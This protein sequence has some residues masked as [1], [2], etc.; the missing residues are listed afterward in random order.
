M[1]ANQF[2]EQIG[3]EAA[4]PPVPP[5][6]LLVT[7]ADFIVG[8]RSAGVPLQGLRVIERTALGVALA[9]SLTIGAATATD[10]FATLTDAVGIG[11]A[12]RLTL[13]VDY[14]SAAAGGRPVI[15]PYFA[16]GQLEHGFTEFAQ[17]ET[18]ATQISA[19]PFSFV[20]QQSNGLGP[21]SLA[22]F[23]LTAPSNT[24]GVAQRCVLPID[25]EDLGI[26]AGAFVKFGLVD[27]AV[28]PGTCSIVAVVK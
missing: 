1:G 11:S 19:G 18:F 14:I 27:A 5:E 15:F 3:F 2:P 9:N 16:L 13:Y 8:E 28:T 17:L 23:T 10:P 20:S 7:E 25:L 6:P 26:P 22:P 21:F 24:V 4:D 12:K